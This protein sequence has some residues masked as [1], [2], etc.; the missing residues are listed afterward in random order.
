M[1]RGKRIEA[2]PE[3]ALVSRTAWKPRSRRIRWAKPILYRKN[4][5]VEWNAGTVQ[6]ISKSGV[7][8]IGEE[9]IASGNEVE[10]IF[11]MPKEIT[12]QPNSKVL[13]RGDVARAVAAYREYIIAASMSGY[14]FL[15]DE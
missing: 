1:S 4:G 15:P 11:L 2:M 14:S 12:G 3:A 7:S 10:M 13:C 6:N 5:L 8:F 9:S